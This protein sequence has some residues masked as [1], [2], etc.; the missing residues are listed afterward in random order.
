MSWKEHRYIWTTTANTLMQD[1]NRLAIEMEEKKEKNGFRERHL[2]FVDMGVWQV[3]L[4]IPKY[5]VFQFFRNGRKEM[6]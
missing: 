2:L 1:L 6:K 4:G 3:R 5:N